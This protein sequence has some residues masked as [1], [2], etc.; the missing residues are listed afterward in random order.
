MEHFL[1]TATL[2]QINSSTDRSDDKTKLNELGTMVEK[3][4]INAF[5]EIKAPVCI[6][7]L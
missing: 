6:L 3:H 2:Q 7:T 5:L 4:S 1:E